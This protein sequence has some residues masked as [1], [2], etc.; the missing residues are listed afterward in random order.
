MRPVAPAALTEIVHLY[1]GKFAD[2]QESV[3]AESQQRGVP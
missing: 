1:A 3:A 2:P